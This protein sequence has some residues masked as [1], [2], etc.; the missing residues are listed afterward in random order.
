MKIN[1]KI[2]IL[3]L[4][5]CLLLFN[6]LNIYANKYGDI[7]NDN[8]ITAY[9]AS[10]VVQNVLKKIEFTDEQKKAAKVTGGSEVTFNDAAEILQKALKNSHIFSAEKEN[11]TEEYK[12]E[13]VKSNRNTK[14][15]L[16]LNKATS[17]PLAKEAFSIIC[18]GGGSNMTIIGVST[19]DN[20]HYE[21]STAAF[22]DNEYN[23]RVTFPDGKYSEHDFEVKADCPYISSVET[24]RKSD[25]S[26]TLEYVSDSPGS[27]YYLLEENSNVNLTSE[28][29]ADEIINNNKKFDMSEGPN[30]IDIENLKNGIS[31]TLYYVAKDPDGKTTLPDSV[32]ISSEIKTVEENN[33]KI[34]AVKAYSRYFDIQ[35]NSPT[36]TALSGSNFKITCPANG[37]LHTDRAET[38]DNINYRLH[39][40]QYYFYK[41]NNTMTLDITLEDGSIITSKFYADYS[42]PIIERKEIVRTG[43]TSADI[44]IKVNEAGK[45]YYIIKDTVDTDSINVKDPKE[46]FESP[47]KK[48]TDIVWGLNKFEITGQDIATGKYIC[49]A[50]EDK[51]GNRAENYEF[52]E[53]P[54][55]DQSQIPDNKLSIKNVTVFEDEYWGDR[56]FKVQFNKNIVDIRNSIRLS[57]DTIQL[58]GPNISGQLMYSMYN[59][60]NLK[61]NELA[62]KADS[63][64]NY[65]LD[66]GKTYSLSMT[67]NY[68]TIFY[69]FIA[70]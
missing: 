28:I 60:G 23:I 38:S 15:M 54:K 2:F 9:D 29:N 16:V 18:T 47:N 68:E 42:A 65:N 6:S 13:S 35:L 7:D 48:I 59:D 58:S 33:I 17:E 34:V 56:V 61:D 49:F 45:L 14:V 22:K 63:M 27:F 53:I 40:N 69:N 8:N 5:L 20:M 36:K 52:I 44:T 10:C 25:T 66:S 50:T 51:N 3:P 62:F 57:K 70:P 30:K 39:M 26:A 41:S 37:V 55:Y 31:Y 46:I 32:N 64:P 4:S 24:T 67:I 19:Q 11:P 21:I 1:K 43:E 12:I